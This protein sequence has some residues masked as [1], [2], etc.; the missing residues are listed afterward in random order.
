MYAYP[1]PVLDIFFQVHKLCAIFIMIP[2][3]TH[4]LLYIPSNMCFFVVVASKSSVL[5]RNG[6]STLDCIG[7]LLVTF[8]ASFRIYNLGIFNMAQIESNSTFFKMNI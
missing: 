5:L 3:F 8:F 7:N 1:S 4:R 2:F 6:S